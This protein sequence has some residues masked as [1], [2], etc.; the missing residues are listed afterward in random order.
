VPSASIALLDV[1]LLVAL[2]DPD[3][4]H[5]DSAHDWF[6]E[7]GAAGWATCPMTENG[8]IRVVT[9]PG[10]HPDPPRPSV[11]AE[12]FRKFCSGSRSHH[13]W[14]DTASLRDDTLFDLARLGG[15]RQLSDIYLLGLARKMNGRLA[16]FDRHINTAA[17]QGGKRHLIV[18][19]PE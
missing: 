12:Q 14:N 15:H 16:T 8:F 19:K 17:V 10:Y 2:F 1:N 6:A 3:H 5:H 9:H 7:E 18:I 13:F 4:V 11:V